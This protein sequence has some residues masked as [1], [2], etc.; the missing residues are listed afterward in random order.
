M[1]TFT[2]L[3][4]VGLIIRVT[5]IVVADEISRRPRLYV[6]LKLGVKHPLTVL[7]TCTWCMSVWIAAAVCTAAWWWGDTQWWMLVALAATASLT[8]GWASRWLDP[9]ED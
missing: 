7:I 9:A 3:L 6:A 1:S 4:T 5:R 2:A 8:A